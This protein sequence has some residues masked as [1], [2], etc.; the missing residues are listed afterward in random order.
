MTEGISER[1]PVGLTRVGDGMAIVVVCDDGSV[2]YRSSAV[3]NDERLPWRE[4]APVPGTR[5]ER[6][7]KAAD[8]S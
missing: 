8:M 7:R 4:G 6:E 3:A 1:K 5:R 2:W